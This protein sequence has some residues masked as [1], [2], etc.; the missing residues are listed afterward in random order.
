MRL[1]RGV[2][3]AG[4]D[5]AFARALARACHGSARTAAGIAE[6]V[7]ADATVVTQW[8]SQLTEAGFVKPQTRTDYDGSQV[9]F[10]ETFDARGGALANASF[11]RP[12]TRAK[13]ESLLAGVLER[14]RVYNADP[15]KP[16]W[17]DEI[18]VF[19]SLLDEAATDLGD[20]DVHIVLTGR[21]DDPRV[22]MNYGRQS[23]R[24]FSTLVE[25][26]GYSEREAIQILKN[27]SGYISIHTEDITRFTD[28]MKVV[29]DRL[30]R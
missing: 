16:M 4:V 26:F 22:A 5:P 21:S 25:E 1:Q 12:I 20:I 7:G 18:T 28:R 10:W 23:G 3:I 13:A 30:T 17:I 6:R 24:R 8:L 2:D 9:T 14:A 11:L 29:Y 15:D 27:R 19:G